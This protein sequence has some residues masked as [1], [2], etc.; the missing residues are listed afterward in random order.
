MCVC[1]STFAFLV[2]V[3]TLYDCLFKAWLLLW[4]KYIHLN[5]KN[6]IIWFAKGRIDF[7]NLFAPFLRSRRSVV[8]FNLSF[9]S[10]SLCSLFISWP[11][12]TVGSACVYCVL[13]KHN[14]FTEPTIIKMIR[15]DRER[16]LSSVHR[17]FFSCLMSL[18]LVDKDVCKGRLGLAKVVPGEKK[19]EE[20]S[21]SR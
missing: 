14:I 11:I 5:V 2:C 21:R 12:L 9:P 15:Y 18:S 3:C 8:V 16:T 19:V 20:C 13:S 10:R 1:V 7:Q 17:L 4:W 6:V